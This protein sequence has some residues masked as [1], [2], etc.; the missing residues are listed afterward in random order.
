MVVIVVV[1]VVVIIVVIAV[2]VV[3]VL[4]VVIIFIVVIG[5]VRVVVVIAPSATCPTNFP[6]SN[7]NI[8]WWQIKTIRGRGQV[9]PALPVP[10]AQATFKLTMKRL[11]GGK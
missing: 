2:I 5:V 3:V 9:P 1:V 6:N 7:K 8:K 4:V 11:S 10:L